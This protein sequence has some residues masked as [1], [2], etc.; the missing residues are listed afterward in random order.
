MRNL[1]DLILGENRIKKRKCRINVERTK[2]ILDKDIWLF[3]GFL[4]IIVVLSRKVNSCV[5]KIFKYLKENS[6]F[7]DR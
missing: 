1:F 7:R 6:D 5:E 2:K 3:C 4:T